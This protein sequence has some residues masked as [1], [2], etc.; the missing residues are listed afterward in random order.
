VH[1]N[2]GDISN[3]ITTRSYGVDLIGGIN[4]RNVALYVGGGPLRSS[5]NFIGGTAGVTDSGK[6]ESESVG[7][8]HSVIGATVHLASVFLAMELDRYTQT[9]ISGKLGLRF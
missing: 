6:L 9:V 3:L 7:G 2:N 4:V 8:F 5:G 1:F